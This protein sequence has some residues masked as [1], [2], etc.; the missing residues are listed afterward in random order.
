M[1]GKNRFR[2]DEWFNNKVRTRTLSALRQRNEEFKKEYAKA[3]EEKFVA[4]MRK[5]AERLGHTPH[6]VEVIGADYINRYFGNWGRVI[7][8][9]KLP[10]VSS[11]PPKLEHCEIYKQE[12]RRQA[13]LFQK[14]RA[15]KKGSKQNA[16][17][18]R[19]ECNRGAQQAGAA[20]D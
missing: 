10:P 2:G 12:F 15:E 1:G 9:A 3:S 16:R 17:Q 11:T 19:A 5:C 20:G 8:A 7:V 14:E 13:R 6:K 4:Y 18:Q